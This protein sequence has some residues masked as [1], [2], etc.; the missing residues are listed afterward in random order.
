[1]NVVIGFAL[2]QRVAAIIRVFEERRI[3]YAIGGAIALGYHIQPRSTTDIDIYVFVPE[4][5]ALPS[6][7]ALQAAGVPVDFERDVA[8]ILRDGQVRIRWNHT[9]V[10]LFYMTVPFLEAAS[11]RRKRVEFAGIDTWV[12]AAED[13]AVCKMLFNR[14]R[15]W[16]D[17]QFE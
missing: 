3:P 15:D 7:Q 6:L 5:D 13:L 16:I 12:L 4:T 2:A 9:Y 1:M 14:P 10:D 17:I 8:L 11:Q